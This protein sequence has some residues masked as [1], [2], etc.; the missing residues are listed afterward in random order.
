MLELLPFQKRVLDETK[1]YNRVAYYLDMGLGKTFVGSEK[2]MS[3][4]STFN[5]VVCQ[6]SKIQDWIDHFK[7]YYSEH[8]YLTELYDLTDKKQFDRF[9]KIVNGWEDYIDMY[10]ES[11]D[12]TYLVENPDPCL[13]IGFINYDLIFRREELL[14]LKNFSLMLDES[15]L[16]NNENAKRTEF[17]LKMKPK[18]VILLSGSPT[19]GKYEKLW[20]QCRL[21]GWN[22]SKK[23]FYDKY[24]ITTMVDYG[25][26]FPMPMVVGYKNVSNLKE[27]LRDHG[28]VF[29]K[30]SEVLTLP[31]QVT[32]EIKINPSPEYKK[33]RKNSYVRLND[34]TELVGDCTLTK[35]LYSRK[36]CGEYSRD[37]LQAFDDLISSTESNLV[38]FYC[39]TSE[40]EKLEKIAKRDGKKIGVVNGKRKDKTDG[41][42]ILFVQYQAG[43]YGLN[44]QG[45]SNRIV[46]FSLPLGKGSCDMWE[47]SKK[48][49]H[50]IG[51]KQTCFYYY[52]IV[53]NSVETWNLE[54]L[55]EGKELTDKLFERMEKHGE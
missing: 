29:L 47:Q 38:V 14:N 20:S 34:D 10:D 48:R 37:K 41:I 33:F 46:Y 19:S 11:R 30:T 36:L 35:I 22:V 21:L 28:A 18:N 15:S 54:A 24:I 45:F 13:Y 55:K 17:I 3:F 7:E 32:Q 23:A 42:D 8:P 50:R 27:E 51:Q 44:L 39:Y 26:G 43:A 4:C 16:I 1:E 9:V 49:I 12:E 40:L 2:M 6:K 25:I 5:L 53:K 31:E 52:L